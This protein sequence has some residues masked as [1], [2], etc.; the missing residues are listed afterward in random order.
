MSTASRITETI[1]KNAEKDPLYAP[2][3][4]RCAT[5]DR[6]VVIER[7]IWKCAC[8]A[9]HDARAKQLVNK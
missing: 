3:C 1:R 9:T 2:Y 7:F 6:M 8:G 5:M 4:L